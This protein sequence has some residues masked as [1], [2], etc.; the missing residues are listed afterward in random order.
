MG[1]FVTVKSPDKEAIPIAFDEIERVEG[2]LSK[3]KEE[4]EISR[5]NRAGEL[6]VSDDT[7]YLLR[8]AKEFWQKSNGAFDISVAPLLDLWGFTNG[9]YRVPSQDEIMKILTSVGTDKISLNDK[10]NLVKFDAEG[11]KIDLG[12]IAKGYAVDSAIKKVKAAGINNCL[13]DAGGDIYALGVRSN[14]AWSIGIQDPREEAIK[15]TIGI[16]NRGVAT[17]GDYERYF[18]RGNRRYTHILDPKTGYPARKMI[19]SVTV[20]ARDCLTADAI[21]TSIFVLG[22]NKGE[23]FAQRFADTQV[24]IISRDDLDLKSYP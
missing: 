9:E 21:A 2:L 19:A 14:A 5:L 22:K 17:S 16:S 3:F 1:T 15:E 23:E 8:K 6:Q 10:D 4:S 18:R 12:A 24:T 13:I 7:F 11:M 20:I